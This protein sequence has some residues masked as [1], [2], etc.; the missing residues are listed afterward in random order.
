MSNCAHNIRLI[1]YI[2]RILK[3][4]EKR[5][6]GV[7]AGLDLACWSKSMGSYLSFAINTITLDKSFNQCFAKKKAINRF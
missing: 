5:H 2:K 3:T 6:S 4:R 1:S 7:C